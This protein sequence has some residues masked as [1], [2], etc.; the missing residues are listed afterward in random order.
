MDRL[1]PARPTLGIEPATRACVLDQN[2][3]WDPSVR[4][5]TL[6]PLS[7]TNEGWTVFAKP[8]GDGEFFANRNQKPGAYSRKEISEFERKTQRPYR[9]INNR[10]C[11]MEG[12][13]TSLAAGTK[14]NLSSKLFG[15]SRLK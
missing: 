13:K 7:Q 4:S 8:L 10:A 14:K 9:Q 1:P 15:P 2:R 5:P 12:S 6:Y 3:T 11:S